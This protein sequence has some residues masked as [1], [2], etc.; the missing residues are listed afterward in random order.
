MVMGEWPGCPLGESA[1]DLF[2]KPIDPPEERIHQ[3]QN[4]PSTDLLGVAAEDE[5]RLL[6]KISIEPRSLMAC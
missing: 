6:P 1:F 2:A 3:Q 4:S 5:Q